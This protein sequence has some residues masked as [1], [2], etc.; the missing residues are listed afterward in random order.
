MGV[1]FMKNIAIIGAGNVGI[2]AARAVLAAEDMRLC[3][4][5]RRQ[6]DT[7]KEF[8][9]VP[10][11]T[12]AE[13]LPTL[14]DGVIISVPSRRSA[15]AAK[16][17]LGMGINTVDACDLHDELPNI[18]RDLH[19][20]AVHGG[21]VAIT[22]AGWDPGLDSVVRALM[23]ATLPYGITHTQFG[24]GVSM[25]HSAAAKAIDDILD[26]VAVTIPAGGDSHARQ[27]YAV[28]KPGADPAVV[29]KAILHDGYF[30]HDETHV[31][32]VDD[33]T[34][35]QSRAHRVKI[36]REGLAFGE[37]NQRIAFEMSINNPAATAQIML[38]ALRAGFRRRPGCYLL[39]ELSP[40][41][42]FCG[43]IEQVL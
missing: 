37:P 35:Y 8:I 11:A 25:G 6:E 16:Y 26:A 3:G 41:E 40:A 18:R 2:Y 36:V 31:I 9:N 29:E 30:E 23:A 21:A 7:V 42:L 5:I 14:P 33:I 4:F 12:A 39:P 32:F 20:A 24:P 34:P 28:L 1:F 27:V 38:A 19:E 17:L 22:G 10:V 13:R 43:G 15:A